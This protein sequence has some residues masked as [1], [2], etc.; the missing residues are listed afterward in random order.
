MDSSAVIII[1]FIIFNNGFDIKSEII[2]LNKNYLWLDKSLILKIHS[3]N[4]LSL[5]KSRKK[6]IFLL[7][8]FF[9]LF[10]LFAQ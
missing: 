7:R 9:I 2:F 1:F 10:F 6:K 5:L 8:I 4:T 3:N